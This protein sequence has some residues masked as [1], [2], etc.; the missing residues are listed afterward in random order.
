MWALR[1]V[2]N[3]IRNNGYRLGS[4]RAC[5]AKS[6]IL[7]DNLE[8]GVVNNHHTQFL[9][10][11][12]RS[13][14][15][16]S[17]SPSGLGKFFVGSRCLSSQAGTKS[18]GDEDDLEDGFSELETASI[19]SSPGVKSADGENTEESELSDDDLGENLSEVA[20][21]ELD[22]LDVET[23]SQVEKKS[24]KGGSNSGLFNAIMAI[25]RQSSIHSAIEKWVEEGNTLGRTEISLAML[26]FR[27][28]RLFGR[29]LQ[30]SEWLE[31]NKQ[32]DFTERDYA[33]RLDLI[34][35][36]HGLQKAEKYIEKIP[37]SFR[38][39][40]I[41][42][43]LLANCASSVNVK[44]AEEVFNKMRDLGLP[45]TAFSC[46]QLLL[47]YKRLDR[48]KIADVLLLMEKENVK[49][50][51]FTYRLLIDTK[52]QSNDIEGMEKVLETMKDEG[53]EPDIWTQQITARYYIFGGL[54]E[55]AEAVLKEMEG[56][57][58]EENRAACKALLPLYAA[59]GKSDEVGRIWKVCE[60]NPR[61]DECLAAIEAWGKL[62]MIENAE[63]VFER[64]VKTWKK[65]NSKN[66]TALLKVYA[67]HK[68]MSKGKELVKRMSDNGCRI[69]PYTW[70]AL[71]KLYVE[72]GEV[73]KADSI[74]Y[75]AS[76][77]NQMKPM[78]CSYMVVLDKY[79]K[80][81]DI[82]NAEKIFHRMRQSGY[83]GRMQP[84]RGLLLAYVTAKSPAYGFR[85]RM[86]AD[87]IFP[88]KSVAGLLVLVDA[89]RKTPVSDLLD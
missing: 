4:A 80:R 1:R 82:H 60:S 38:G 48:K 33:S 2:S 23:G 57:D 35:K 32:L 67:N 59:L 65:L 24:H 81:G 39:E 62:G 22:L 84:Y 15:M 88:N 86:K 26:N 55:K 31:A 56:D 73:E 61:L 63:A 18:S 50:S 40:V 58:I 43:T 21:S 47:L 66:Y 5:C 45:V 79:A 41:Y 75:K 13:L 51:M 87:N 34:A 25:P 69:G 77:Q 72:A 70:D 7:S 49:P 74:L 89:F 30:L 28:R 85:E 6:D 29:A 19:T 71:V 9:A 52:G 36:V 46:N 10:G 76:Q 14:M 44:K 68:M 64:M 83:S 53:L 8:H 12:F 42:R 3:P 27:K 11:R 16:V 17:H 20:H 78:Y 37:Q 54:K